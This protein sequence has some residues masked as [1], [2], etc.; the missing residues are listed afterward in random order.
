MKENSKNPQTAK[1]EPISSFGCLMFVLLGLLILLVFFG[2][3]H[4]YGA[5]GL[6]GTATVLLCVIK[7]IEFC[8]SRFKLR[9]I[10]PNRF[11]LWLVLSFFLGL[12]IGALIYGFCVK[13]EYLYCLAGVS[14]VAAAFPYWKAL[15]KITFEKK[16]KP[17]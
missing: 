6:L 4:A 1:Q 2:T 13:K 17:N 12:A 11:A 3:M 10:S 5:M 8:L 9:I 14:T 16:D 15:S 7:G